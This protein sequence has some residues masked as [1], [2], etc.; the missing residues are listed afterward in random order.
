MLPGFRL[1]LGFTLFYLG[2]IVLI[3]LVG[4]VLE[5]QFADVG[6]ILAHC[7]DAGGAGVVSADVW[8]VVLGR[9]W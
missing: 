2:L 6:G 7:H 5:N 4:G 1:T 3:P 9:G 8:R